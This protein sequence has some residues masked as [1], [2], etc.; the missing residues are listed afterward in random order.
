MRRLEVKATNYCLNKAK[1]FDSMSLACSQKLAGFRRPHFM[2]TLFGT[3]GTCREGYVH[4]LDTV[5]PMLELN[6]QKNS[7]E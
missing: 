7:F 1:L 3:E 4:I 5:Y 6:F 2:F